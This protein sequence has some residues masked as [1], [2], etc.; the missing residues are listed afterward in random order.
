MIAPTHIVFSVLLGTTLGAP[1]WWLKWLAIGSLL[2]DLDQPQSIVGKMVYPISSRINKL[3]GHRGLMHSM[4][5]WIPLT[6]IGLNY[7]KPL[8]ILSIGAMTH[9]IIDCM[10]ITGVQL[11]TPFSEKI[12]VLANKRY[13]FRSSSRQEMMFL[14]VLCLL[15]WGAALLH[16]RGGIRK[17]LVDVS[18]SYDLV[19]EAY[20]RRGMEECHFIGKVRLL[21]GMIIEHEWLIVGTEEPN[22]LALFDKK[23]KKILHIPHDGKPLRAKLIGTGKH[24]QSV[25]LST[26][27]E[28]ESGDVFFKIKG[29]WARATD[30][31]TVLGHV[32]YQTGE[33]VAIKPTT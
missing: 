4:L 6:I 27:G 2:P 8:G 12:F 22:G 15:L 26:P 11:C 10:T 9:S 23:E 16:A 1:T 20:E 19:R 32:L 25:K 7:F 28:I 3:F 18:G 14:G 33:S 30:G 13:R 31:S 24:W 21:D 29:R 17:L 5:V